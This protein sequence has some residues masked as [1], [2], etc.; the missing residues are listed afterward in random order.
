MRGSELSTRGFI[1]WFGL[2]QRRL[3]IH[4]VKALTKIGKL[5]LPGNQVSSVNTITVTLIHLSTKELAREGWGSP[6]PPHK[7]VDAAPHQAGGSLTCR[8]ATNC[9]KGPAHR[10]T[11]V[12][13]SRTSHKN[14]NLACSF[15]HSRANLALTLYKASAK[16][17]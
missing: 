13:H 9:S 1:P 12:V 6:H 4:V 11:S 14:L 15:T 16:T 8:R 7:V 3:Y 10:N 2:P 17:K 5:S